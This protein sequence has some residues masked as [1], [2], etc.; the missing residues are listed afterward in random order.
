MRTPCSRSREHGIR[1][2]ARDSRHWHGR[3]L[4]NRRPYGDWARSFPHRGGDDLTTPLTAKD[5]P[6]SG[7]LLWIIQGLRRPCLPTA[8]FVRGGSVIEMLMASVALAVGVI[9][10]GLPAAITIVLG[11][12]RE[13]HGKAPRHYPQTAAVE[14]LGCTTV[15][16][17]D[18]TGTLT[19]NK[20]T[21]QRIYA[22]VKPSRSP[23]PAMNRVASCLMPRKPGG[24]HHKTRAV[25][26]ACVPGCSATTRHH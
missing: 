15:I 9:P 10:E 24:C 5:R 25:L 17:S 19:Q 6:L 1:R 2:F 26:S 8:C 3:G 4:G 16:C 7:I 23:A 20:M 22:G 11:H 13:P 14:T 21:V 12:R 18:K